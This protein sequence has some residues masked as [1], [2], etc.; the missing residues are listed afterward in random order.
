MEAEKATVEKVREARNNGPLHTGKHNCFISL[1]MPFWR[2]YD[3]DMPYEKVYL[4]TTRA[5]LPAPIIG[6]KYLAIALVLE[7]TVGFTA[8]PMQRSYTFTR[9]PAQR[10]M[11][12]YYYTLFVFCLGRFFGYLKMFDRFFP[13]YFSN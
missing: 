2:I 8:C 7:L 1:A 13:P 3:L 9:H 6:L 10:E 5:C 4:E 11:Q 12:Y